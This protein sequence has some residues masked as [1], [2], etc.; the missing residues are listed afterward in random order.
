MRALLFLAAATVAAVAIPAT[1]AAADPPQRSFTGIPPAS[2]HSGFGH[3]VR[4][5]R[6]RHRGLDGAILYYD[7]EYQGDTAWRSDSFNDWWHDRPNRAYPAWVQRNQ[8]CERQWWQGS[9]LTC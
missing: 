2:A 8:G 3:G 5:D 7:R 9:V 4:F 6:R 1:P